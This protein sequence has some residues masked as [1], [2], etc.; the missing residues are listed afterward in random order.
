MINFGI[1]PT[2]IS[3]EA[4]EVCLELASLIYIGKESNTDLAKMRKYVFEKKQLVSDKLP[5][6]FPEYHEN[7]KRANSQAYI[8]NNATV[9]MLNLP[10]PIGNGWSQDEENNICLTKM[11]NPPAPEGFTEL[12]ICW[13]KTTCGTNRCSCKRNGLLCYCEMCENNVEEYLDSEESETPS[14][15]DNT[16]D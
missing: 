10:S 5:P 16:D 12:T 1:D 4:I 9:P 3:E 14:D 11:L 2:T 8:W 15:M 13:C 7:I 6:T